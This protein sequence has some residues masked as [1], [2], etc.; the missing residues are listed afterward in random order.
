MKTIQEKIAVMQAADDGKMIQFMDSNAQCWVNVEFPKDLCWNWEE[1][2]YRVKPK[3]KSQVP[4]G[5]TDVNLHRDLFR[6]NDKDEAKPQVI[7]QGNAKSDDYL[8]LGGVHYGI[9]W[10]VLA[11]YY[12]RSTDG[13][14]GPWHPCTKEIKE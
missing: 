4:F 1:N 5:P 11:D 12:L 2:D 3:P 9:T 6:A 10:K 8:W 7:Y 14:E 13:D